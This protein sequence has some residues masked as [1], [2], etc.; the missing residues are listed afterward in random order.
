MASLL[1]D[2]RPGV[3]QELMRRL[4]ARGYADLADSVRDLEIVAECGCGESFCSS[5]HTGE[6]KG[7]DESILLP[8]ERGDLIVEAADG[9]IHFV[10]V[11]AWRGARRL[12]RKR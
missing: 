5:F 12:H 6:S 1:V 11:L 9:A 10:E 7:N 3:A 8:D 4:R 2:E